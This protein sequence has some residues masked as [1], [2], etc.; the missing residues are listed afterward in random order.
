MPKATV[1]GSPCSIGR[2]PGLS[3][4]SLAR[5]PL[6]SMRWHDS[7]DPSQSSRRTASC[8][9]IPGRR[10]SRSRRTPFD[11]RHAACSS[12]AS[13]STSLMTRR[14]SAASMNR[15]VALATRP[16]A[17][18]S[19][20]SSSARKAG[21]SSLFGSLHAFQPTTPTREPAR[22]PSSA[23]IVASGADRSRGWPG[24]LSS[25]YRIGRS[26]NG[27]VAAMARHS[28]PTRTAGRSSVPSTRTASSKRGSK[29]VSHARFALCSRSA[30][31]TSRSKPPRSARSR[32]RARRA[33]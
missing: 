3:N 28:F 23:R 11:V 26:G 32:S 20:R 29:P 2:S 31:T 15:P 6:D 4:P 17:P 19:D 22:M 33:S 7:G 5:G 14:P 9:V 24:R 25:W 16:R 30:Y 18:T 13:W 27:A 12:A 21:T 10:P 8:S 1:K